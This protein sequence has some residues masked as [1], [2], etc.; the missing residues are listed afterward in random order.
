M[1][2]NQKEI[3]F[4]INKY[5]TN[6]NL[7]LASMPELKN[8]SF[9][10]IESKAST[11]GLKK[12][13]SFT[14]RIRSITNEKRTEENEM[15]LAKVDTAELLE[16]ASR[17]GFI[18]SQREL[19]VDRIYKFPAKLKPFKIGVVTDPHLGSQM[20]QIT[21]L[22]ETYKE[23][24]KQKVDMV[25]NAGDITEGNGHLYKGQLYE[26]FLHGA[27]KMVEY[28][29]ENYPKVKGIT[30]YLI[31]GNHDYSFFKSEGNDVCAKIVKAR[32]D[33]KYL[34]NGG[35]YINIGKIK[36]YIMHGEGGPGYARSYKLQKAIE[37]IPQGKKPHILLVGGMHISNYLPCYRG[38]VGI[39]LPC[40]QS[41]THYLK[42]KTLNPDVGY[43]IL[44]VF[45]DAKGLDHIKPDF[46][47]FYKTIEGDF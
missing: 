15:N 35:A 5:S 43:V 40:F 39:L 14:S 6:T 3:Q 13:S 18:H 21:F 29:I 11:M 10:S 44:E 19:L 25:L 7:D 33:I 32:K 8:H 9:K 36:I 12:D 47:F 20:Q 27:D 26:M 17:R 38:V 45:P 22:H 23:F 31:G 16:E 28:A 37:Q 41:Q 2:W 42:G 4:L 34:G 30:T 1:E 46:K 24:Q